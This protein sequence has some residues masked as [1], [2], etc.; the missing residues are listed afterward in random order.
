MDG[1][2]VTSLVTGPGVFSLALVETGK[3]NE[4]VSREKDQAPLLVVKTIDSVK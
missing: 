2:D 1:I 3:E 4:F